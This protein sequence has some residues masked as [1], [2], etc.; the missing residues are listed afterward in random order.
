[1][2]CI[3]CLKHNKETTFNSREHVIPRCLGR[4]E[5][6]NPSIKGD[7]VCDEC[8]KRFSPLETNFTEDSYEGVVGQRFNLQGNNSVTVR[9][10][11][12]K[13]VRESGF[14][15]DF[16]KDMF[17]FLEL[18]DNKIVAVP[19]NQ[20]KINR[21]SGGCRIFLPEALNAI[22]R[23]SKK[24][25]K[26]S[27]DLQKLNQKDM[28]IFAE[29]QIGLDKIISLLNEFGVKYKE[30]ESRNEQIDPNIRINERY[31]I[32]INFEIARVLAKI[33]F[34]YFAYCAV[35]EG[36]PSILYKNDFNKLRTFVHAC[37]G[38][39]VKEIVVSI[40]E[41]PILKE[42]AVQKKR[43]IAHL[44]N[45][46]PEDGALFTR[47]TFFGLTIYKVKLGTL[48]EELNVK[49]FGCGHAF[50]P[51]DYRVVNL[52]QNQNLKTTRKELIK[53]FGLFKRF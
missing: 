9:E 34:N 47:M 1:M 25:I 7:I 13:I 53:T 3:Y 31:E 36:M 17:P 12:F 10:K 42:E 38:A 2:R 52:S 40:S 43:L 39:E 14:S 6:I 45:F 51:F 46:L 41:E 20:I 32:S 49:N 44:I 48:P 30:K 5:P 35:Q 19:K 27:K 11:Q 18:K 28:M 16:F 50:N 8:N 37:T 29:N 4:F 23:G 26:L 24:F 22:P 21:V 33:A 15:G